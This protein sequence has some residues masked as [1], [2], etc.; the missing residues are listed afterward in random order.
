[1]ENVSSGPN[2]V[3]QPSHQLASPQDSC[4]ESPFPANALPFPSPAR[5]NSTASTFTVPIPRAAALDRSSIQ[6][7]ITRAC[8]YCQ[9]KKTRC[10][11]RKPRCGFCERS[12]T[13]CTYTKSKR[14]NQQLQVRTLES[15]I[16]AYESLL[17]EIFAGS[18]DESRES[19]Q[20]AI[21]R[22][23]QASPQF[24]E[25]LL[26]ANSPFRQRVSEQR[27]GLSLKRMHLAFESTQRNNAPE[28]SEAPPIRITSIRY[29][30]SLVDDD[31]A[32]H[33]LS[34]YFTW[35]NPTWQLVDQTMFVNDLQHGRARFCSSLLV[36]TLLFYGCSFSFNLNRIT[37][38]R[39][40][41]VLGEKLYAAIQRLWA[42]ERETSDLPTMQSC[43]LIGLLCCTFGIDK[44]GTQYIMRG[45]ELSDR[46]NIHN[47][48]C[49]YFF[50]DVDD[51]GTALSTCQKLVSWAVFDIQA[52][53]CQVYRKQPP[54]EGPP[55]V[56]L[57]QE[58]AAIMDEGPVW[59]PYPFQ[60]PISQPFFYTASWI[61]SELVVIVNDIARFALRFPGPALNDEDWKYG[62][63]LYQR[64]LGWNTKLPWSVLPRHNTTP[65]V[66]C[67]HMYYQSTVA[68]LCEIFLSNR[69][70]P[71]QPSYRFDPESAKSHALDSIG[72]LVLLFKQSHGWKS[73]PIVMLHYFCLAGIHAVS[74]L[75]PGEMKWCLVLESS[76]V[77]LWHMS[78]GWGRLCKAFL[79]TIHLVITASNLDPSLVPPKVNAIFE[80]ISGNMWTDIDTSALAADYT[81]HYAEQR[82]GEG[83]EGRS[84]SGVQTLQELITSMERVSVSR[85]AAG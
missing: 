79:R 39:E 47:E 9:K 38:R 26:S 68:S 82:E 66:I 52:L 19:I 61:R 51:N 80:Q 50:W 10:D 4:P 21:H 11:G 64:L 78:L 36:H 2:I 57:T 55:S 60:T 24:F 48:N 85:G 6:P 81:V 15:R 33:L 59:Y 73:I 32:S 18:S 20:D 40:E 7:R 62:N 17:E 74:R 16:S 5:T 69:S 75:R 25:T 12:G 22:H 67:L 45:A 83:E 43:I 71:S 72:T 58:E 44:I 63:S 65:H 84:R 37:D 13:V 76:V 77:G 35:E 30:T 34:L 14:E 53:A 54:F 56:Q 46:L 27:P 49:A 31:V 8:V 3:D 29:W 23:F 28:L 42:Q 41:K 1:M 70:H